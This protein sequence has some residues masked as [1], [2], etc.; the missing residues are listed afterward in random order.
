MKLNIRGI[1]FRNIYFSTQAGVLDFLN[2]R[3]HDKSRKILVEDMNYRL[4]L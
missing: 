3:K 2:L 1:E 4:H